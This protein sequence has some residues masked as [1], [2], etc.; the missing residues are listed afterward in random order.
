MISDGP[1][2]KEN[3]SRLQQLFWEW[4]FFPWLLLVCEVMRRSLDKVLFHLLKKSEKENVSPFRKLEIQSS[5]LFWVKW[6]EFAV[7]AFRKKH[8]Y[9]S[10][11]KWSR[12]VSKSKEFTSMT[13]TTVLHK[14]MKEIWE[15]NRA[16][17]G[18]L[19]HHSQSLPFLVLSLP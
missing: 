6:V 5:S 19:L 3:S 18:K 16:K 9:L 12:H 8:N 11:K 17:N 4:T 2:R 10:G 15:K 7:V 13:W 14:S 1:S